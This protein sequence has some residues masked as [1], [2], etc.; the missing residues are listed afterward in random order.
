MALELVKQGFEV[1]D[2]IGTRVSQVLLRAEALVPGAGREAIEP[3]LADATLFIDAADLQAGRVVLDG[4]VTCQ[5]VYRQGNETTLRALE[6]QAT[7]DHVTELPGAEPGM[8]SR[9][10]GVVEHVDAKYENGHMI[11][12]VTCALRVQALSLRPVEGIQ[13]VTGQA[14]LETAYETLHSVKLAAESSEMALLRDTVALPAALDARAT[15]MDWVVAEVEDV[16]PDLGGVRVKGRVLVETL[17]S[18]GA[19]GRP[20][21]VVRVPMALDQLVELPEWLTGDVTAELDVRGV[22]SQIAMGPEGDNTNLSCEAELRVRVLANTTDSPEAL[23]DIYATEG[24]SL[25]V[26]RETVNLCDRVARARL[27]EAVRG[28]VLI[29]EDAPRVGSVIAAQVKPVVGEWQTTGDGAGRVEGVLEVSV[30]YMPNGSGQP[31]SAQ[32]ELPF[33]VDVPIELD[34][35]SSIAV[36]VLSAEASALMGDRLDMKVQLG[37]RCET[38]DR[39]AA[40]LV[41]NVEAGEPIRRRP[42]IVIVWPEAGEDAW[43]IGRRYAIPAARA[44]DAAPGKALVLKV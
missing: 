30:L 6:A 20:A 15:L 23:T 21:A 40:E 22:R 19:E 43:S 31:A 44:A 16:S 41:T 14:G 12:L 24:N 3:L 26:T 18:S 25:A 29:G 32:S 7:L 13:S 5:A 2:L 34:E 1:E 27:T 39:Q 35:A 4:A 10:W 28:T 33:A 37:V 17:V 36:Q 9:V 11:F 42:G 8:F 38:R